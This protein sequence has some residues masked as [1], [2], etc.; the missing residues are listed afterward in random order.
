MIINERVWGG[1]RVRG[2]LTGKGRLRDVVEERTRWRQIANT[3]VGEVWEEEKQ[4]EEESQTCL[5]WVE[6]RC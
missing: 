2:F 5:S 3:G 1:R 4:N 6:G